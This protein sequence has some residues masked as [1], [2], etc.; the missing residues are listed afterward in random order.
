MKDIIV[1]CNKCGNNT[2][3]TIEDEIFSSHAVLAD[4]RAVV[5]S[6]YIK[7]IF[8]GNSVTGGDKRLVV[9]LECELIDDF[10]DDLIG[11]TVKIS[12]HFS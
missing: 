12:E 6:K 4:V 1:V 11:K 8:V 3:Y 9:I 7:G 10:P 5:L 2:N